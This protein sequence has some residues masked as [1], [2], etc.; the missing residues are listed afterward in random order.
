MSGVF[1]LFGDIGSPFFVALRGHLFKVY[2][3]VRVLQGSPP[4]QRLYEYCGQLIAGL[5][6]S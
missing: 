1:L 5:L 3:Y 2:G 4:R 6:Y